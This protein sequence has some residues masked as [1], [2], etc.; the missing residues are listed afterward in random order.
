MIDL[1]KWELYKGYIFSDIE[2]EFN[3]NANYWI[4]YDPQEAPDGIVGESFIIMKDNHN[5]TLSFV[6]DG[7]IG[8]EYIYNLIWK[9]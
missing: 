2:K 8:K 4:H 3:T 5:H 1:S 6:L 7:T 9:G